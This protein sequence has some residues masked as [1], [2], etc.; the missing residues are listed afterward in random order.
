V[1]LTVV[2]FAGGPGTELLLQAV[3][4][5]AGLYSAGTRKV[6][7]SAPVGFVPTKWA[8]YL[9]A[10][11]E[12]GDV[13]AY[14]HYWELCVLVGLRDG[15]RSGDVFVPGPR[16]YADQA[17]FFLSRHENVHFYGTHSVDIDGELAQLDADGYRPLRL[18][19]V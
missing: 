17:S 4:M 14:R 11:A 5:L 6:P 19:A 2:Q 7:A 1:V 15:L 10:A 9:G 18:A 13:T 12:S 8:G 16:R 3:S